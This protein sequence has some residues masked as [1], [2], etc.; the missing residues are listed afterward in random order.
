MALS[1]LF[2]LCVVAG[3]VAA[4][5]AAT[6]ATSA[7]APPNFVVLLLDDLDELLGGTSAMP[8]VD[9]LLR[10]EGVS[11]RGFVDVPVCCPSRTST[12]SGRYSHNLNNSALGWCGSFMDTHENHTWVGRMRAAGYDTSLFGKYINDYAAFCGK[13]LH[14]PTD[15]S[16]FFAMCDD[17]K[18][19]GNAFNENGVERT[20]G[21]DVYMT[22]VLANASLAHLATVAPPFFSYIAPHAPHVPAT[23]AHKHENAPLPG[24]VS[25]APRTPS[26]DASVPLHHWVVAQKESLSPALVNFSDELWA[27]RLR[28]TMSVDDL[29]ASVVA[30]LTARGLVNNTYFLFT[31]DHGY[32]MGQF[33]LPSGKFHAYENDLRVPFIVRGP[34]VARGVDR[35]SVLVNN[36]DIAATVLELAGVSAN[37]YAHDGRSFA[38]Q[39]TATPADVWPRDRLVHEYWGLGY[40]MRG[41]CHNGTTACPDGAEALEDAPSNTWSGLRI[42]NA[43]TNVKDAEYRPAVDSPIEV[44]STNFTVAFDLD[45]D[46]YELDNC[47][48]SGCMSAA[49]LAQLSR[50]LWAVATCEGAACP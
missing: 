46:P 11:L 2:V 15:W 30:L 25:T 23:P 4:T 40:T 10:R 50:E 35:Q 41:P 38:S 42:V 12:L 49:T 43:T 1:S 6:G 13:K 37:G 33:R 5:G 48:L 21:A 9:A 27:R 39:L 19:F 47:A 32:N 45:A 26:W 22:D 16:S 44:A 36:V 29:V 17:N 24:N 14:V 28:A 7:A 31:S 18:Y 20:V 34:G 8:H 3:A